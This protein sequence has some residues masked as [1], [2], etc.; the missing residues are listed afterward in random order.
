MIRKAR[1][2]LETDEPSLGTA[3]HDREERT[4]NPRIA[5]AFCGQRE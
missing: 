2:Y 1:H 4:S 3:L 5:R